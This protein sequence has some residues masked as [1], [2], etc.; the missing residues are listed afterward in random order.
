[1]RGATGDAGHVFR[2]ERER[3]VLMDVV[4][5]VVS[6][7]KVCLVDVVFCIKAADV[8]VVDLLCCVV[9]NVVHCCGVVC[10]PG[11]SGLIVNCAEFCV[12]AGVHSAVAS[13]VV[14][15]NLC[16]VV[17]MLYATGGGCC[18]EDR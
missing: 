16:I 10:S 18:R 1:M 4:C 6:G 15:A 9:V 5:A 7:C 17:Q 14:S 12:C 8:S 13:D 2:I 3:D 11:V